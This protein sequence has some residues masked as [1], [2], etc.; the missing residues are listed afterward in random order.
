M[1]WILLDEP[2]VSL[3]PGA[4]ERLV[5]FLFEQIKKHK[6]QVV[7]ST[8]SPSIIR[9]LPPEAIKV[10]MVDNKTGKKYHP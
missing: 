5:E 9:H 6:H 8:H 3:H 2:E 4:Q 1:R 7:V 10:M